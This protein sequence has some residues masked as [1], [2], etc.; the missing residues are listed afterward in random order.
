MNESLCRGSSSD[1]KVQGCREAKIAKKK[2]TKCKRNMAIWYLEMMFSISAYMQHIY[3]RWVI[4]RVKQS[5]KRVLLHKLSLQE[6]KYNIWLSSGPFERKRFR[7]RQQKGSSS[8]LFLHPLTSRLMYIG[9]ITVKQFH[10]LDCCSF[11]FMDIWLAEKARSIM[12]SMNR[13]LLFV[14]RK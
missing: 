4:Q 13:E 2:S 10:L 12:Q 8:N 1:R 3:S 9:G 14:W 11:T 7:Q 6:I 5:I